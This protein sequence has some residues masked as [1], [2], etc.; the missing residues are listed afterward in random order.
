MAGRTKSPAQIVF[1]QT[2]LKDYEK[3]FSGIE[4]PKPSA[5]LL[6]RILLRIEFEKELMAIRRNFFWLSVFSAA[7]FSVIVFS[8]INFQN[9]AYES[10]L[11]QIVSLIFT[12]FGTIISNYQ[13]FII[14]VVEAMPILAI[15]GLMAGVLIFFELSLALVRNVKFM[16]KL[17]S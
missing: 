16:Y 11:F 12:D 4:Q 17:N 1:K 7:S 8:W 15:V 13:D 10:G 3:I 5:E 9:V 2:V 14:S 6:G